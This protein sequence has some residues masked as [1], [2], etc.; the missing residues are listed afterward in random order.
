MAS[1][2]DEL[3]EQNRKLKHEICI[4]EH[5]VGTTC[6]HSEAAAAPYPLLLTPFLL[7]PAT[8][9]ALPALAKGGPEA[10]GKGGAGI[11]GG[12]RC[13]GRCCIVGCDEG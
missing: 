5:S 1:K 2:A 11:A 4:S 12:V 7:N 6:G 9:S 8:L 13:S 3:K 10:K